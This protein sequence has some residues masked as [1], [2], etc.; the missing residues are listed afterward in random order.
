MVFLPNEIIYMIAEHCESPTQ[1]ALS[2]VTRNFYQ[3]CNPLLYRN[4]VKSQGASA[5]FWAIDEC[6]DIA[7][8]L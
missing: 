4:N 6:K 5:V 7:V 2:L 1:A 3:I 8:A